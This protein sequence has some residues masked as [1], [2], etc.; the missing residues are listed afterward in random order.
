MGLAC[1]LGTERNEV[2][3]VASWTKIRT[4]T[5]LAQERLEGQ[6]D[7]HCLPELQARDLIQAAVGSSERASSEVEEQES[8]L[9][10]AWC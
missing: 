3:H 7:G 10:Q 5:L 9:M 6:S 8:I 1:L 2:S 4:L